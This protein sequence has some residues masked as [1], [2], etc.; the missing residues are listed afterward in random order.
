MTS[1][2]QYQTTDPAM[3][4]QTSFVKP[5]SLFALVL[6]VLLPPALERESNGMDE[7]SASGSGGSTERVRVTAQGIVIRMT[8][9]L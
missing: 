5:Y 6:Q 7:Q 9:S 2:V 4:T 8:D 1:P 3:T